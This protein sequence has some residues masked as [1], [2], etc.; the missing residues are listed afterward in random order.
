MFTILSISESDEL[1][2]DELVSDEELDS[3]KL[4]DDELDSDESDSDEELDSD[5][6]PDD[7]LDSDELVSDNEPDSDEFD[8]DELVSGEVDLDRI[9]VKAVRCFTLNALFFLNAS[10]RLVTFHFDYLYIKLNISDRK[11]SKAPG[12]THFKLQTA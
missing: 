11:N 5:E 8:S 3:D 4:P 1:D 7:E 2:L 10:N 12:L 6:L 9:L